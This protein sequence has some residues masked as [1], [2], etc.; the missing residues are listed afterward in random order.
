[1]EATLVLH[2]V[3]GAPQIRQHTLAG[4]VVHAQ[5]A[6]GEDGVHVE[7]STPGDRVGRRQGV[8][9]RGVL[10]PHLGHLLG[11]HLSAEGHEEVVLGLVG[12]DE[13][14]LL[15]GEPL[16]GGVHVAEQRVAP[17]FGHVHAV[18]H[19]SHAGAL[20][21]G[22]V[23]VP[24]VLVALHVER[25]LEAHQFGS[26]GVRGNERVDLEFAETSGE[27]HVLVGRE[28]LVAEEDHLEL[29][30]GP[31]DLGDQ[32]IGERAAQIDAV[33]NGSDGGTQALDLEVGPHECGQTGSF[34]GQVQDGADAL[35][36]QHDAVLRDVGPRIPGG[37]DVLVG[38]VRALCG[39]HVPL[40]PFLTAR[41]KLYSERAHVVPHATNC[42][43]G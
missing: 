28:G 11:V 9:H 32:F 33:Q 14:L 21:P 4:G 16:V 27:R 15:V 12:V 5:N 38:R 42:P 13:V 36:P 20:A 17:G 43:R 41:Q 7:V 35:A 22:D 19:R 2:A 39:A 6:V 26:A 34:L 30:Q 37:D 3:A 18:Q 24:G 29:V 40:R 10:G 25:L 1:M 8:D 23:V 31:A